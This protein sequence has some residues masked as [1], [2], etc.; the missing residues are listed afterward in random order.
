VGVNVAVLKNDLERQWGVAVSTAGITEE[1][2]AI[3]QGQPS[4]STKSHEALSVET[5]VKRRGGTFDD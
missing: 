5:N 1:T 4:Y 2:I 3:D